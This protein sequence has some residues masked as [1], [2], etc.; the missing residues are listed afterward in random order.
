MSACKEQSLQDQMMANIDAKSLR[1][2]MTECLNAIVRPTSRSVESG[3]TYAKGVSS[4]VCIR[5]ADG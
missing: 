3:A 1:R 4:D 2:L 5:H